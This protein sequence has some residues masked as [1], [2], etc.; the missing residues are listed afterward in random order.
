MNDDMPK[1]E[2]ILYQTED[3]RTRILCRFENETIW[4]T[5]AMIAELFQSTPQN[6]TIHLKAIYHEGE[7]DPAATCKDYLQVAAGRAVVMCPAAPKVRSGSILA[8]MVR[9]N[10]SPGQRPGSQP[11]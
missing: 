2:M 5:Q 8:P 4:Q 3:G 11:S 6:V 9:F 7:F 1:S 10:S